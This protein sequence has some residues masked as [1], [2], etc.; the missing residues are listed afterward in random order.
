M[1]KISIKRLYVLISLYCVFA[2]F[3]HPVTPTII[4]NLKLAEYMFGVAFSVM[5]FGILVFSPFWSKIASEYGS[6]KISMICLVGYG[7]GQ[8]VFGIATNEIEIIVGRLISG[9]FV[10]GIS[11]T[12]LL[13]VIENQIE[14]KRSSNLAIIAMLY[15]IFSPVGYLFG[16]FLGD[17][18]IKLTFLLQVIGLI[19]CGLIYPII[20][21]DAEI[22]RKKSKLK[23][24]IIEA[25]PIKVVYDSRNV[26]DSK[27]IV[28]LTI[29]FLGSFALTCHDQVFNYYIKDILNFPPSYN[30]LLKALVG[31]MATIFNATV[32]VYIMKKTNIQKS[33]ISILVITSVFLLAVIF[34]NTQVIFVVINIIVYG[35]F[36]VYQPVVQAVLAFICKKE[37]ATI[38]GVFNS[39]KSLGM[40]LGSLFAGF[41]YSFGSEQAF[42]VALVATLMAALFAY[43][44]NRQMN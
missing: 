11:V 18:S 22:E 5:S 13:Y 3:A 33:L 1:K 43:I 35:F 29:V 24:M 15:A 8:G 40:V 30:G 28:Y 10:G 9:F 41:V 4:H 37:G 38:V 31:V 26:I 44:N 27:V 6:V 7:V 39:F 2:N 23:I 21:K 14:E 36:A 20:L 25:N 42:K 12:Q 19:F 34:L 32:C 16:G 17:Y